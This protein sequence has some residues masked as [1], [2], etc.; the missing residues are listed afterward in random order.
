MICYAVRGDLFM[1][2]NII[3]LII[4][5]IGF[6]V[7]FLGPLLYKKYTNGENEAISLKIKGAA[8]IISVIGMIIVFVK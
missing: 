3:G 1:I 8:F 2:K 6:A 7:N 4:T 5:I